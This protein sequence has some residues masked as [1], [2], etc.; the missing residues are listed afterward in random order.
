MKRQER[1]TRQQTSLDVSILAF[2]CVNF[3]GLKREEEEEEER[4]ILL[5]H[6]CCQ[7]KVALK[8][9]GSRETKSIYCSG[10]SCYTY[11][12]LNPTEYTY[13]HR[14]NSYLKKGWCCDK[15]SCLLLGFY[16]W[17]YVYVKDMLV[18]CFNKKYIQ[19]HFTYRTEYI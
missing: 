18:L 1:A 7:N 5:R 3:R 13:L 16:N 19:L 11:C 2:L 4:G 9:S 14:S 6:C 17:D 8:F 15:G 12:I 10:K